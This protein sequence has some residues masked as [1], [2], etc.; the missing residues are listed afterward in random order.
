MRTGTENNEFEKLNQVMKNQ[1][2]TF[3]VNIVVT[4]M[5]AGGLIASLAALL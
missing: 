5:F 2:R 1:R 4:A 3:F